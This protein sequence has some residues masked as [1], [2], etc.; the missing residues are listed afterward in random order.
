MTKP[1]L[2]ALDPADVPASNATGYPEPYRSR[3]AG[4]Y[5]KRLG[6]ASGLKN[7]GVNLTTLEPGAESS[8][9]CGPS[10]DSSATSTAIASQRSSLQRFT[11]G[12]RCMITATGNRISGMGFSMRK[13]VP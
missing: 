2:P 13:L 6:D 10:A 12:T 4:R 1:V 9:R 8:M 3:V 5:K 7:F 11:S